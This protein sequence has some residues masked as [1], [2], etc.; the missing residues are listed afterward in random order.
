[1]YLIT[2]GLRPE[3]I[4]FVL[5]LKI[6]WG[7]NEDSRALALLNC[8]STTREIGFGSIAELE[9]AMHPGPHDPLSIANT[10]HELMTKRHRDDLSRM[11]VGWN[12]TPEAGWP[13]QWARSISG[14]AA[15]TFS[16]RYGAVEPNLQQQT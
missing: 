11:V 2:R 3:V 13:R 10:R 15:F 6:N 4:D 5:N 12:K 7:S 14:C 9:P 1:L 16:K 8:L